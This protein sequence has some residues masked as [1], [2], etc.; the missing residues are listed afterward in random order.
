MESASTGDVQR[1]LRQLFEAGSAVGLTDAQLLDRFVSAGRLRQSE[2]AELAFD[3][4]MSRHGSTVLT[5]CRQVLGDAHAAEDAFQTTFL[6]LV[7]RSRS[8]RVREHGSLGPWLYG[9]AY[10][11]ALKARQGSVRRHARERRV[12]SP[13][14]R[15]GQVAATVERDE[16]GAALHDEINRLPTKYREPVVLCYFEGQTHDEAAAA[17]RWPVGTVRSYL[18]RARDLLRGRLARRGLAPAGLIGA[19]LLRTSARGEVPTALRN[20]T[21]AAAIASKPAASVSTVVKLI[22]TSLFMPRLKAAGAALSLVLM[23]AGLGL[24]FRGTLRSQTPRADGSDQDFAPDRARLAPAR[25]RPA[26]VDRFSDALPKHAR[27]RM[28][29]VRFNAGEG[30]NQVIFAADTRTLFASGGR[31]GTQVWDVASGRVVRSIG[32]DNDG[33]CEIARSPDGRILA[34]HSHKNGD[35]LQLWD[36][37][38]GRE[39]RRWK[40]PDGGSSSRPRFSPDGKTLAMVFRPK[41]IAIRNGEWIQSI[42]L[43]NLTAPTE[44]RRRLDGV[45][46]FLQ[47]FQF[48][49]DSKT[50]G[51]TIFDRS[52]PPDSRRVQTSTQL[53]DIASGKER[54]RFVIN[55][56]AFG[57]LSVAFSP[58]GKR[59]FVSVTDK[60]I[61]IYDLAAGLE[62]TPALNHDHAL[63]RLPDAEIRDE[64]GFFDR[65]VDC[66]TFS[67][68]GSILAATARWPYFTGP[69]ASSLVGIYLWDVARGTVL[70]Y[71]PA[72]EQM[73]LSLSFAPDG[74]TIAS[75]GQEP[76]VRLWDVATGREASLQAGHRSGILTLAVSPVDGTVFTGGKDGTI[77]QWDPA[78]GRELGIIGNLPHQVFRLTIT[79]DGKALLVGEGDDDNNYTDY[80]YRLWLWSISERREIRRF[81]RTGGLE[82]SHFVN[83]AVFSPDG[84]KVAA[85]LDVFDTA[86]GALLA[87]FRDRKFANNQLASFTPSFFSH[88]G[89]QVITAE[90]EGARIWDIATGK[91][92]RWAIRSKFQVDSVGVGGLSVRRLLPAVMSHDSR[93]M[94]TSGSYYFNG[95][96]KERFDPAIR[97]WDLATGR[98]VATLEGHGE[99]VGDLAFS[100]DGRLL[101]SCT[102]DWRTKDRTV[103]I[104]DA[105]S[106]RELRRLEGHLAMVRAVAFTPDD[107]SLISCSDDATALVWDVADLRDN[108]TTPKRP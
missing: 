60:T 47:D 107:R 34:I 36:T 9:V 81:P 105:A 91:E 55:D 23:A 66:L 75:T 102:G 72:H 13:G 67:P 90:A 35:S 6:V 15:A 26:P 86:T 18:S 43:W 57:G 29:T 22:V 44:H 54:M 27:A 4:I 41:E 1:H 74:K 24:I 2:S 28:G 5:V 40:L 49:P 106:G 80:G 12:A 92:V 45:S 16:M 61:R 96:V 101:A 50:L 14:A 21:L 20:A 38:S 78:T 10:R 89:R 77:R 108:Q 51:M 31:T 52:S 100:H 98:E 3:T 33:N 42:D 76:I 95:W 46:S 56:K 32:D 8:L 103:R 73:I 19:S 99:P 82:G 88:D 63:K 37:A 70:R 71:F 64:A 11:T 104:W 87:T 65:T 62:I 53:W 59:L 39:L 7:R 85:D 17:L 69:N 25:P 93:F 84:T 48:S 79:P 97:I 94:A 58:D 30:M 68:D 83:H